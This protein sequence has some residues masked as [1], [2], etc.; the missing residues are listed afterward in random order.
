MKEGCQLLI[1]SASCFQPARRS[2][3]LR[4]AAKVADHGRADRVCNTLNRKNESQSNRG[5]RN[6]HFGICLRV[7]SA[8][9][10][11]FTS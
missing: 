11:S 2:G 4:G 1:M 3:S 5:Q 10:F 7:S 8:H 9:D 6:S